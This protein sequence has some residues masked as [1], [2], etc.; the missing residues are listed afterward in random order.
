MKRDRLFLLIAVFAIFLLTNAA[1]ALD[2]GVDEITLDP[3][4]FY[5]FTPQEGI[6]HWFVSDE[7]VIE[8]GGE[9]FIGVRALQPGTA[10]VFAM[11]DDS[12]ETDSCVV[13]VTGEAKAVKSANL[14]YQ[15]LTEDD[16]AKVNDPSLAAVLSLANNTAAFPMGIGDLSGHEYKVLLVVKDGSQQK[17]ADAAEAMGLADTWAYE[18][19]NM[20][21]LRGDANDIAKL[22]IDC[23]DDIVSVETDQM[24]T[25]E[26]ID[27][28]L[29]SKDVSALDGHAETLAKISVAH[30]LGYTG[31]DQYIAIID[32]GI[33]ANHEQ[34]LDENG[35]SRVAYEHCYSSSAANKIADM[36]VGGNLQRFYEKTLPVCAGKK[37]EANSAAPS[38]A[39]F[40]LNFNHG[41]HVAG[42][43]AGKDGVAPDAKIIAIQAFTEIIYYHLNSDGKTP[44]DV[45]YHTSSMYGSDELKA[46]EYIWKLMNKGIVPA[47]LNMSYG[48]GMYYDYSYKT[49]WCDSYFI[50]FLQKGTVP[51]AATGNDGY[52]SYISLPAASAYTFAVGALA[53]QETSAVAYYSNHGWLVDILAPGTGITS[54]IYTDG[55]ENNTVTPETSAY[56]IGWEGTSMATPMV[57]GAFALLRQAAHEAAA[58]ELQSFMWNLAGESVAREGVTNSPNIS[59]LSLAS[60]GDYVP[61][62]PQYEMDF[63]VSSGDKTITVTTSASD[64]AYTGY[65]VALYTADGKLAASKIVTAEETQT[66][67]F[68]KLTND[69]V[70]TVKVAGY[71]NTEG[72]NYYSAY[73]EK[74]MVPMAAPTGLTLTA[75]DANSVTASWPKHDDTT[76][77]VQ[78]AADKNFTSPDEVEDTGSCDISGLTTNTI[79]YFRFCRYNTVS[80][81]YSPWSAA[82]TYYIPAMPTEDDYTVSSGNKTIT[83][84]LIK[85][86]AFDGYKV[87]LYNST[88]KLVSSKTQAVAK[89]TTITF[90]KL[91]NEAVYT[92]KVSSYKTVS[93]VKYYSA[94]VETKT[95]PMAVPTGLKLQTDAVNN[96]V[97]ASWPS[98]TGKKV[99]LRW[100]EGENGT[101]QSQTVE[102]TSGSATINLDK[103]KV[104]YFSFRWY[105]EGCELYSPYS[106]ESSAMI[107]ST[108]VAKTS[109]VGYKKIRVYFDDVDTLTGHQIKTYINSTNKLVS[110]VNVKYSTNKTSADIAK[111]TNGV[112]YRFEI[113]AYTTVGKTTYYSEPVTVYATPELKPVDSD[114]PEEVTASGGSKKITVNWTKDTW[115][116]GHYIELYRVDNKVMVA[117]AYVANKASSY[118][119]SGSKI[120]YDVPYLVRVWKYNEKSPKAI[121]N[122]YVD[123]YAVSLATPG[124]FAA[125]AGDKSID[126]TWTYSGIAEKVEVYYSTSSKGP[127]DTFGCEAPKG[128]NTCEITD[129][130]NGTLYYVKAAAAYTLDCE[131]EE[132]ED[133]L[134]VNGASTAVKS[135][136]PLPASTSATVTA[137][138]KQVT[139]SYAKDDSVTGHI[140]QL[141]KMKGSKASLVKTVTSADK[142]NDVTVSFTGLAN[143]AAYRVTICSYLKI[144]KTTYRGPLYTTEVTPSANAGAS[145]EILGVTELTEP[146]DG[147]VDPVEEFDAETEEAVEAEI[148]KEE[149]KPS[150]FDLFRL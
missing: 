69:A 88:G 90:S 25:I 48:S 76:I 106:A 108:P 36:T 111:L 42:I 17:I 136:V 49:Y 29:Q 128:T 64:G 122:S 149:K 65:K 148:Q 71:L 27:D 86:A 12:G 133:D 75:S 61:D 79:Y 80:E 78:Y 51:C 109:E 2:L 119:F 55:D 37:T 68:S 141:Y 147:F 146:F 144:G 47:A 46:Y 43:A 54:A 139:V 73:A 145:K 112:E 125:S 15:D 32:T 50:K 135:V 34:F 74:T 117:N 114:A 3:G 41:S 35:K 89:P 121:G 13:T 118:T 126:V 66:I 72:T 1:S 102:S 81:S 87:D 45:Y 56:G 134:T 5:E 91:T 21:A 131:T 116:T 137:G 127:F 124:S 132:T 110:T 10:V 130:D 44:G 31:E 93:K 16:L 38:G 105:H 82:Y 53:N 4:G 40:P 96:T 22:L 143:N 58:Y 57:A 85:N 24:Y 84:K 95:A 7:S 142:T 33:K 101:Y 123:T 19:V 129:L 138:S 8:L 113:R 26:P 83:V 60:I 14:Y 107:L 39:Q 103:N 18:F 52:D 6:V 104:Y 63:E 92:V 150:I 59:T 120:D 115:T 30:E 98:Y 70:Y 77:K 62:Q 9:E 99:E 20:A 140:I 28:E 23:R 100:K 97:T 67:T 11:A 94:T